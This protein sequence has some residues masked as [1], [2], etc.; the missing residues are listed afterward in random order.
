MAEISRLR[1]ARSERGWSKGQLIAAMKRAAAEADIPLPGIETLQTNIR[2]WENGYVVPAAEYRRLL[3]HAYGLSDDELGFPALNRQVACPVSFTLSAEGLEYHSSLLAQHIDA[4]NRVGPH[5]V[6]PLVEQQVQLL[7]R[8]LKEARG[9][10]RTSTVREALKFHEFNGWLQQDCGHFDVASLATNRACDL[11]TELR[12]PGLGAYLL[13]R[14]SNV[15]TD[16]GDAHVGA[17]LA[18]A[19]LEQAPQEAH[20]LRAVILRQQANA[21]AELEDLG[22]C[23]SA[24]AAGFDE[25]RACADGD[26]PLTAY[27]N[28]AYV[29]MEAVGCW[30]RL[31]LPDR[32]LAILEDSALTWPDHLRRDKGLFLARSAVAFASV[33]DLP[34]A[35]LAGAD[36]VRIA[37]DTRSTRTITELRRLRQRLARTRGEEAEAL[38]RAVASLV[39]T[40]A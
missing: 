31:A 12:D 5:A 37:A 40:A 2:R 7:D 1:Q 28:G 30:S 26:D 39:A 19:A 11:S 6:R 22:G 16:A 15:A 20:R 21:L 32:A 4:D 17:A 35:F 36:A 10:L 13:M 34:R 23:A 24:I 38:R 18:A 25:V 8:A 9:Q 33:G 29:A 3:R 27:C 14:K